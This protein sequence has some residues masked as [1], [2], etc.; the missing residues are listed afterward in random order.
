MLAREFVTHSGSPAGGAL[1]PQTAVP[2][3][4]KAVGWRGTALRKVL[5]KRVEPPFLMCRRRATAGRPGLR[6][7]CT[8][9]LHS[10][11]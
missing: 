9:Q 5:T 8:Q 11:P 4:G 10:Q 1:A 7:V 3:Q 2:M 6:R